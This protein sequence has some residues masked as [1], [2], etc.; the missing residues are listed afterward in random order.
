MKRNL[1]KD[2]LTSLINYTPFSSDIMSS[3]L[4]FKDY[5][6]EG[7]RVISRYLRIFSIFQCFEIIFFNSF[8]NGFQPSYKMMGVLD[9]STYFVV[10]NGNTYTT[11]LF[12]G[13]P[14][15]FFSLY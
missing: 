2:F 13:Y 11:I 3:W 9:T 14:D 8:D 4:I 1:Y 10:L 6:G 15:Y 7:F 12:L 5:I